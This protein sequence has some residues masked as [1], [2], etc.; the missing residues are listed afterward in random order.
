MCQSQSNVRS[1]IKSSWGLTIE[2][3]AWITALSL[4]IENGH[5]AN[6]EAGDHAV[7]KEDVQSN[8]N[9]G[10]VSLIKFIRIIFLWEE[11]VLWVDWDINILF[12]KIH[13]ETI[14]EVRMLNH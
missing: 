9:S 13:D 4:Q 8:L 3:K 1:W 14:I 12:I 2:G 11:C 5:K 10:T 7:E 6:D